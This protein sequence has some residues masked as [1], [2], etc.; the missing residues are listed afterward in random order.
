MYCYAHIYIYVFFS[1]KSIHS[2][3]IPGV[4]YNPPQKT[5]GLM[6]KRR[7]DDLV[8]ANAGASGHQ[9]SDPLTKNPVFRWQKI[10][11]IQIQQTQ[12]GMSLWWIMRSLFGVVFSPRNGWRMKGCFYH[13]LLQNVGFHLSRCWDSINSRGLPFFWVGRWAESSC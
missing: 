8:P 5:K 2:C 12:W 7:K 1:N 4:F 11:R 6:T 13:I 9:P 3:F 10:L